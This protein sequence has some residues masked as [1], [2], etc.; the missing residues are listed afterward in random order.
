MKVVVFGANGKVGSLVTDILLLAGHEV[1]AFVHQASSLHDHPNLEIVEGDIYEAQQVQDALH[2]TDAVISALGSW[3]TPKKDILTVG[4]RHIIPAMQI[5]G[6]RRII[7]LTGAEARAYGDKLSPLHRLN[8]IAIRLL[9]GK[10][11][12]DG[13]L[14]IQLLEDTDFD[15]TVIRSPIMKSSG[16]PK[17]FVL[18]DKR[19][20][21]WQR[22]NRAAVATAIVSQLADT[23]YIQQAPFITR[24]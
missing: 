8:H 1:R 16:S 18:S 14:H 19:P 21:A 4:M 2:G 15:W 24:R 3:G 22:I 23:H 5:H 12:K 7:S 11:L 6:T 10:V 20:Q 9:A 13:E 17:A